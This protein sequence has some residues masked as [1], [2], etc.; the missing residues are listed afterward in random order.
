M[1]AVIR[2]C[3]SWANATLVQLCSAGWLHEATSGAYVSFLCVVVCFTTLF[4]VVLTSC[5]TISP[6][7]VGYGGVRGKTLVHCGALMLNGGDA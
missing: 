3:C 4:V 6:R 1:V 2:G 5:G 7:W